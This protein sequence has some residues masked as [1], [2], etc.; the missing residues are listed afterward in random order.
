MPTSQWD[1][2]Y[3]TPVGDSNNAGASQVGSFIY[4][5]GDNDI[6]VK[7]NR[8]EGSAESSGQFLVPAKSTELHATMD[9]SDKMTGY[10]YYTDDPADVFFG[11]VVVDTQSDWQAFDWGHT[12]VPENQLSSQVIVGDGR[13]C[14]E[15]TA[16]NCNTSSQSRNYVYLT[17]VADAKIWVDYDS[18]GIRK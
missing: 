10:E 4:N 2:K 3:Y 5:P 6:V 1:H 7:F 14:L 17:P 12:L 8:G 16:S 9:H 11:V 18:D 13:R 15:P